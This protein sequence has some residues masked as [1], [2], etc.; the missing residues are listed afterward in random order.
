MVAQ[1]EGVAPNGPFQADVE[2]QYLRN[3]QQ[4]TTKLYLEGVI[5]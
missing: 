3:S 4:G 2:L 1:A 5:C